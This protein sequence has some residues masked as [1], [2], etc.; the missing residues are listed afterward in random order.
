MYEFIKSVLEWAENILKINNM[1]ENIMVAVKETDSK[2]KPTNGL[3]V[4]QKTHIPILNA[5]QM[6]VFMLMSIFNLVMDLVPLL[7]GE[8]INPSLVIF[9]AITTWGSYYFIMFLRS[10]APETMA[11]TSIGTLF[12]G[13]VKQVT[14]ALME[15][16]SEDSNLTYL[17]EKIITWAVREWDVK[18]EEQLKS[19]I[20][21]VR[22]KLKKE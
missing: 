20:E 21:Y 16:K 4:I 12:S 3:S 7:F 15:H 14:D 5:R 2:V 6:A 18:N 8:P 1:E 11:D 17:L 22:S 9:N 10:V 13:F 19:T